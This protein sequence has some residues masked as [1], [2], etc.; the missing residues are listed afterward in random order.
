MARDG[1]TTATMQAIAEGAGVSV[2]TLY[3]HFDDREHVLRALFDARRAE[4]RARLEAA[5]RGSARGSFEERLRGIIEAV[6]GHFDEHPD[7][8]RIAHQAEHV[9]S[10]PTSEGAVAPA[11]LQVEHYLDKLV[12]QAVKNGALRPGASAMYSAALW[13]ILRGVLI[14]SHASARREPA[15]E[16]DFIVELF[17]KGAAT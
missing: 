14:R 15:Q 5:W 11:Q 3:N 13:G 9:R 10:R 2:G 17:L 1:V 4:L 12:T 6:V 7:F 8:V 16:T